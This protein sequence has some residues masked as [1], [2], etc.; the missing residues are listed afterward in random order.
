M[1][2]SLQLAFGGKTATPGDTDPWRIGQQSCHGDRVDLLGPNP[3][4]S[5]A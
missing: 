4:D 3:D 1:L 5:G 2:Q